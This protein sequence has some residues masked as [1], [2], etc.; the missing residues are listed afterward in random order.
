MNITK[1]TVQNHKIG[2]CPHGLPAGACPICNGMGGGGGGSVKKT[3]RP[4]GEMTWDQCYAVWQKML[5]AKDLAAQK[6]HDALQAQMQAPVNFAAR[7]ENVALK[8][9][10]LADRLANFVQ[11]AQA[12]P[13]LITKTLALAAKIAIPVLNAM[14]NV[15][16]F[17]QKAV[18]FVQQKLADISDKLNAIFGELKNS[19]EK[20]ISDKLKDFKKRFKSLFGVTELD[21]IDEETG[22]REQETEKKLRSKILN[23]SAHLPLQLFSHSAKNK[24]VKDD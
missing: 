13:T 15:V 11:K 8:M 24:D 22:N 10:G 2:T 4:A 6:K 21:D 12:T 18:N 9:V 3:D 20:K 7:L 1:P 16:N 17:A 23:L 5:Q 19:I 14:Q